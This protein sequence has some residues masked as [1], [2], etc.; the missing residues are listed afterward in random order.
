MESD[1][2]ARINARKWGRCDGDTHTRDSSHM[3]EIRE[4][5]YTSISKCKAWKSIRLF[6]YRVQYNRK[7]LS[8]HPLNM[9]K[10]DC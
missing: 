1:L 5:S 9:K 2:Q 8:G 6:R 4:C 3:P 7:C 10:E